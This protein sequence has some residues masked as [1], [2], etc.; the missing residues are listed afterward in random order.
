MVFKYG[1]VE[2]N[3]SYPTKKIQIQSGSF[4]ENERQF[5]A[6]KNMDSKKIKKLVNDLGNLAFL[7]KVSNIKKSKTPPDVYFPEKIKEF[8]NEILTAQC[9]PTESSYWK[10]DNYDNFLKERRK[11]IVDAINDLMKSLG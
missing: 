9:I 7:S 2:I 10:L 6:G 5:F 3:F 8:G 1:A 11:S 4:F